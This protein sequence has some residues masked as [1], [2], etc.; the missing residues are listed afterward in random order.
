[1]VSLKI[2][3]IVHERQK[4]ILMDVWPSLKENGMLIYSTCTFNPGENE[5]NIK[6]L[7]GK[8]EAESVRLIF[9]NLRE[10]QKL[11]FR[12]YMDMVFIPER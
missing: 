3:L 7:T 1:M 12:G 5:E 4:R 9:R 10:S 6:W 11:I 2:Q 8:Q